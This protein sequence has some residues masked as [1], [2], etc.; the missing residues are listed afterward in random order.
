MIPASVPFISVE[1]TNPQ[2]SSEVEDSMPPQ[3]QTEE[4]LL[5]RNYAYVEVRQK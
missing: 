1:E 2:E 4:D 5:Y 3:A